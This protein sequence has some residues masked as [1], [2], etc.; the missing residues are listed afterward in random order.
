MAIS[1]ITLADAK[2]LTGDSAL[3]EADLDYAQDEI[4]DEIRWHPIFGEDLTEKDSADTTLRADA[5]G[6]A[7]AWQAAYRRANTAAADDTVGKTIQSE[8]I[9]DYSVSYGEAALT[10]AGGIVANRAIKLL[11]QYGLY[12]MTGISKQSSR[13]RYVVANAADAL[14]DP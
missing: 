14:T 3:V 4:Y 8:S 13:Y 5:L 12:N 7:I 10:R 1:W 11:K 6:R 2:A 9:G